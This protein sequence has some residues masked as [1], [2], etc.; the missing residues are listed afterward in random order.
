MSVDV[1][2]SDAGI[3]VQTVGRSHGLGNVL[4]R[5]SLIATGLGNTLEW[6][7]WTI[8]AVFAPYIAKAMFDTQDPFSA[9]LSTL[10]IFAVGFIS[11]PLGGIVFGA[12]ADRLGRSP[13]C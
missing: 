13:C 12:L 3:Q 2:S 8:Y 4:R 10:A 9:L 1:G 6:Y 7:D 5:K 11:R